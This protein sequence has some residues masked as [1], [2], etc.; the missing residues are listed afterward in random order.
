MTV[1][2]PHGPPCDVIAYKFA[3]QL[4]NLLQNPSVMTA[5]NLLIDI[6]DPLKAYASPDG[7]LGDALSGSVYRDAYQRMVTNPTR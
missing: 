4:L 3:P 6:R 5:E 1:N 2:V 7:L